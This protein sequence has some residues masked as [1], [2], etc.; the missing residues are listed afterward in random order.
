MPILMYHL[1]IYLPLAMKTGG[2]KKFRSRE[3]R[4]DFL[5]SFVLKRVVCYMQK[6]N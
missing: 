1:M 4:K 6:E 5:I 3:E 2:G